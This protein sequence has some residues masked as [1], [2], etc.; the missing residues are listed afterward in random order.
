MRFCIGKARNSFPSRLFTLAVTGNA[1]TSG[2]RPCA[3]YHRSTRSTESSSIPA[4]VFRCPDRLVCLGLFG[5][6]GQ[7][8]CRF[9]GR[10]SETA[11]QIR[12]LPQELRNGDH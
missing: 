1:S 7:Q 8:L 3:A 4:A 11:Q 9:F 10:F 2:R 6:G 5:D 12:C